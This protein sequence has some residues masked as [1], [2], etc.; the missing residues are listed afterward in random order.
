MA[1]LLVDAVLVAAKLE[2]LFIAE[3]YVSVAVI[4]RLT[5]VVISVGGSGVLETDKDVVDKND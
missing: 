5:L 2:M 1:I 3:A 4:V